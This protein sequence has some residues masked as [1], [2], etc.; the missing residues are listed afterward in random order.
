MA[1]ERRQWF[2]ELSNLPAK[3]PN[4]ETAAGTLGVP[5]RGEGRISSLGLNFSH[6]QNEHGRQV[7]PIL[8]CGKVTK[9]TNIRYILAE[10]YGMWMGERGWTWGS[11]QKRTEALNQCINQLLVDVSLCR[12]KMEEKILHFASD[13]RKMAITLLWPWCRGTILAA[14]WV[15][16]ANK[17]S[18]A[19][20]PFTASIKQDLERLKWFSSCPLEVLRHKPPCDRS[21]FGFPPCLNH[22][23]AYEGQPVPIRGQPRRNTPESHQR[24]SSQGSPELLWSVV[25]VYSGC[26]ELYTGIIRNA[27]KTNTTSC[28]DTAT[29]RQDS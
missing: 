16:L 9:E 23:P 20:G 19:N 22:S 7:L 13:E 18:F 1:E 11:R 26:F 4:S 10:T 27:A 28:E 25:K 24:Q 3:H 14:S 29:W 6:P 17:T 21:V 15:Q 2:L 12:Q 8:P 5:W